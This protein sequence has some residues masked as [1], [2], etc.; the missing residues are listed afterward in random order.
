LLALLA[1]PERLTPHAFNNEGFRQELRDLGWLDFKA[2]RRNAAIAYAIPI[3]VKLPLVGCC[4]T[5]PTPKRY[6]VPKF[7][8]NLP[9]HQVNIPVWHKAE[10]A[11]LA[12]QE[13]R[14]YASVGGESDRGATVRRYGCCRHRCDD[15]KDA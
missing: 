6:T 7:P 14:E 11:M 1:E 4:I 3:G 13:S 2:A 5:P 12:N 9:P 8:P 10:P 15:F